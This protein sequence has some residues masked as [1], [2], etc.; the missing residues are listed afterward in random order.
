MSPVN[1]S[2]FPVPEHEIEIRVRYHETDAQGHVHHTTY[3]NYFEI[4]RVEMLRAAG[5]SYRALEDD[6][7]MLVVTEVH[8]QFFAPARYDDV[9]QVKARVVQARGVRIRH[10]YEISRDGQLVATGW[11]V[12]AAIGKDGKVKRLP[13]WLRLARA[14]LGRGAAE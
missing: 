14:D 13:T 3:I 9:L 2:G 1:P 11:T 7:M 12:V 4:A 10:E 5:Y 6:G 8:C